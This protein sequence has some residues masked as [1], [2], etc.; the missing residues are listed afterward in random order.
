MDLD[1][2]SVSVL[3]PAD[4]PNAATSDSRRSLASER[5][6]EHGSNRMVTAALSA[7]GM[8]ATAAARA[9]VGPRCGMRCG[10]LRRG[11]LQLGEVRLDENRDGVFSSRR[12]L[13]PSHQ[14]ERRLLRDV[15]A[16]QGPAVLELQAHEV[17]PL[18]VRRDTL[19]VLDLG[20]DVLDRVAALDL[21]RG[22]RAGLRLDV[23]LHV[24]RWD[25]G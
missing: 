10:G 22:G 9:L 6:P 17:Q 1:P 24:V 5:R 13:S 15:V 11:L 20:L 25:V 3:T 8:V 2:Q 19:L 21:Q 14:M 12:F 16:S 4:E 23:N 7:I 18:L